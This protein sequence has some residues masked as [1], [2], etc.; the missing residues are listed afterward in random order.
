MDAH[1]VTDIYTLSPMQLGMLYHVLANPDSP[2]YFEQMLATLEGELDVETFERAWQRMIDRHPSLRAG[3]VWEGVS[4]PVQVVRRTAELE[5]ACHD[6]R[7]L[8]AAELESR[9][10][11]FLERDRRRGFDLGRAPLFRLALLRLGE[12]RHRLVWSS[13]HLV[14]DAWSVAILLRE[15]LTLYHLWRRGAD[16]ELPPAPAYRDYVG[17]LKRQDLSAAEAYWRRTLAGFTEPTP[18]GGQPAVGERGH[19]HRRSRL[20]EEASEALHGW[21]REAGLTL[22]NLCLGAWGLYLAQR[23]GRGDVVF[24]AVTSGR[25]PELAGSQ[26]MVGLFINSLPV[27]VRIEPARPLRPWLEEIQAQ[28]IELHRHEHCPLGKVLEWS[29]LGVGERLFESLVVFFNVVDPDLLHSRELTITEVQDVARSNFPLVVR[30]TPSRPIELEVI[31][32]LARF[33]AEAAQ[34][35]LDAFGALLETLAA[36]PETTLGEL[37]AELAELRRSR[38]SASARKRRA[39]AAGRL[40]NLK[41]SAVK[42]TTGPGAEGPGETI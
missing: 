8:E 42:I 3:F 22:H 23:A 20:S 1:D 14:N 41:P 27:R 9:L 5:L 13:S 35:V 40:K 11:D 31:H 19:R 37:T 6:W 38:R 36:R 32:D 28:Q 4:K 15:V 17:W 10:E 24:G 16:A 12:D 39:S 29:E 18:L 33:D 26:G 21:A 7:G 2:L 30:I 25:P 34:G